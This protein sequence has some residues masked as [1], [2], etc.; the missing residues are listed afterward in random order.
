MPILRESGILCPLLP[1]YSES[2]AYFSLPIQD[3]EGTAEN[4]VLAAETS[5]KQILF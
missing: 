4:L 1:A 2:F 3:L 5:L